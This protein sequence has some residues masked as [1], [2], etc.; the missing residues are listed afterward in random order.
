MAVQAGSC[1]ETQTFQ[2]AENGAFDLSSGLLS[3]DPPD[4]TLESASPSPCQG[5]I[6][7][8][9]MGDRLSSI[10]GTWKK[11]VLS[12]RSPDPSSALDK[13]R[14]KTWVQKSYPV[15]G[16]RS[17]G[18]LLRHFQTP[19]LYWI[20][21]RQKKKNRIQRRIQLMRGIGV[22]EKGV[23]GRDALVHKRR[24]NSS[25]KATQ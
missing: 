24:R 1:C 10:A 13:N 21:F 15:L 14:A 2:R 17:A 22:R 11:C 4:P 6:W 18:R 25:Q 5:P 3:T 20:N 9:N 8:Q 7:H 12:R 19:V 16:L 23:T